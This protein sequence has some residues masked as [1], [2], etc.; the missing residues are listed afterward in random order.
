MADIQFP[1]KLQFLFRPAR[2]KVPY[3]GR[4]SAKS[5]SVARALVLLASQKKIRV[6]CGRE[7]Q[8]SIKESVLKLLSDQIEKLGLSH[9]FQV[10]ETE[11]RGVNGSEFIFAGLRSNP[12]KIKSM[13]D[14]DIAWIDEAEKVSN[15]SWELLIPTIR[16]PGSEIWVTFN[17]DEETDPAYQ[18]FVVNTPPGAIVRPINWQDNPWFPQVLKG[19]KDYLY[20]VDPEAAAHVWGGECRKSSAAQIFKG[21]YK[22]DA[23]APNTLD[24]T[25]SGPYFGNDWGF[26][27]DPCTAVK[28]W[29]R[30]RK[31]YIEHESWALNLEND[32]IAPRWRKDIPGIDGYTIRGDSSRPE[33]I[34]HVSKKGGLKVVAAEKWPGSVEDGIAFLKSFEEIIIHPRCK[35]AEFEAK[36]Y[37]F[38]EDKIT[39]D[40]LREIVDKHNHI[41]DA[42]RY[43]LQPAIKRG[44]LFE[45][46]PTDSLHPDDAEALI[47]AEREKVSPYQSMMGE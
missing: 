24:S 17:P 41:W 40:I 28:L 34:S 8:L 7:I 18:R 30:G 20:R 25:W 27:N 16:K 9:K 14:V 39:G 11:I 32:D 33:T 26:S 42:V 13:E 35:H 10:L 38:K 21:K 2:Y 37:K 6:F 47:A 23:F 1:R 4:G 45:E 15:K 43:A 5:W 12:H 46:V 19:E 36:N 44:E 22:I 29:I 3:G 31:L